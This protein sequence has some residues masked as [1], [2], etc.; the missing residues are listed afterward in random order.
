[1]MTPLDALL[2]EAETRP[3]HVAFIADGTIWSYRRLATE[4]ERTARAMAARGV[5][6]GDRVALHMANVPEMAIAC[7]ACFRIGAI[8]APLNNR[9]KTVELRSLLQRLQPALYL[10]QAHL[11]PQAAP[12]EPEILPAEARFVV[13][14]AAGDDGARSWD[15][16]FDHG[17]EA[18]EPY[19][20]ATDVPALLLT[21]SGTTGQPKFVAHTPATLTAMADDGFARFGMETGD[22]MVIS[23]P[24]VHASGLF[25][26][27]TAIHHGTPIV[28]LERFD[29]DAV[30]D[31]IE[32][33]RGSWILG[34]PFMFAAM[35]E[36]QR[37]RPRRMESLRFCV[38]AGD[39]CPQALQLEF[40][41]VFGRPLYSIW[42]M[43]E[44]AG[45]FAFG[46]R[47][48]SVT[49]IPPGVAMRLVDSDGEP[50]PRGTAGELLVRGPN[51]SIGYWAGP[52]RI[53]PCGPGGWLATGDIMRQ[54]DGDEL[55]FVSRKKDLIIRGGS[56]I[57][58]AE[59]E[60]VLK[61]HPG[62][63]EAAVIGV[64][65][66]RL[67]QR[68]AALVELAANA[69]DAVLDDILARARPQLADYKLPETL[70][71]VREIP[72]NALGKIDRKSLPALLAAS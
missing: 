35:L 11:Y 19:H 70:R 66:P 55:W 9:F 59:V 31:A 45:T 68:V 16:L 23:C 18:L 71:A 13:G 2:R 29:A 24:M 58:P 8:A 21:T 54:G 28:L 12:V 26:F 67:G 1:M 60:Q 61:S 39:V 56:N 5:R 6:P 64:P 30:L 44:A 22:V 10:G 51:V 63:R 15:R 46:L 20:P 37:V 33:H 38:T 25:T 48:G 50:V 40:P 4:I 17:D 7:Y 57:A 36:R 62:V 34:L 32:A 27:L 42:A 49:R 41:F 53:D 72:K 52:G 47:P 3:N 14:G 69:D 65:D 43:T